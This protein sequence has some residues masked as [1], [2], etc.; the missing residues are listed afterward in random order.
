MKHLRVPCLGENP[1]CMQGLGNSQRVRNPWCKTPV[2]A[3]RRGTSGLGHPGCSLGADCLGFSPE[4][5]T[6][7]EFPE[8]KDA[9]LPLF[10]LQVKFH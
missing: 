3:C 8:G 1:L 10:K 5:F 9:T 6:S 4:G 2:L 7:S